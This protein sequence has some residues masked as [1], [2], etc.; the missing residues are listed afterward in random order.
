MEFRLPLRVYIE[1]TDAGGIVFYVN[2]LKYMERARTEFMR[3]LG[4][5]KAAVGNNGLM[6]VV[7]EAR[8]KY[9]GSAELDDCLSVSATIS[10]LGRAGMTFYQGVYR[11]GE[12]LCD[13]D[14]RI[15]CVDRVT[16]RPKAMPEAMRAALASHIEPVT[17]S[18]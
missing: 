6:F 12:L 16:R 18:K 3:K 13:G 1:D 4:F 5:G 10:T 15:A 17:L 8:V 7:S 9:R 14:I 2:Y 11:D